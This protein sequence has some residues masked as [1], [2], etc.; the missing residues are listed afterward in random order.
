MGLNRALDYP[1]GRSAQRVGRRHLK[2]AQSSQRSQH[3]PLGNAAQL[4]GD[5]A[6]RVNRAPG[7]VASQ[8]QP[9]FRSVRHAPGG[10]IQDGSY[11]AGNL[12]G[13][14]PAASGGNHRRLGRCRQL[15]RRDPNRHVG[16]GN[17]PQVS[18]G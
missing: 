18:V 11:P 12:R 3:G 16:A 9:V 4:F 14:G 1:V 15:V 13:P 8:L 5:V 10:V 7:G 17:V 6:S 2:L